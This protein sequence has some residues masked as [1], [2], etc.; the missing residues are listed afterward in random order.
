M[1][2]PL[3]TVPALDLTLQDLTEQEARSGAPI[4]S[5]ETV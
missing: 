1:I 4:L 3:P 5:S 2:E